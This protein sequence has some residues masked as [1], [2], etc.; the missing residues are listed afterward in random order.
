MPSSHA[1]G[2]FSVTGVFTGLAVLAGVAVFCVPRLERRIEGRARAMAQR[3]ETTLD[4]DFDRAEALARAYAKAVLANPPA[5]AR[6]EAP[7]PLPG[8]PVEPVPRWIPPLR[9]PFPGGL[10]EWRPWRRR[11]PPFVWRSR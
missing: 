10:P 1:S 5:L 8:S 2:G 11:T 7:P 9:R 4:G 6:P 3:A